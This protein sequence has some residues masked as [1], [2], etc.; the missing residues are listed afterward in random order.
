MSV[1]DLVWFSEN[2]I[3][4]ANSELNGNLGRFI[5]NTYNLWKLDLGGKHPDDFSYEIMEELHKKLQ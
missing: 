2:P 4:L 5:R 3:H 1:D